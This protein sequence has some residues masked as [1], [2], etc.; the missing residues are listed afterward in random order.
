MDRNQSVIVGLAK[1]EVKAPFKYGNHK[2]LLSS[3]A[4]GPLSEVN[5]Q[6]N[7]SSLVAQSAV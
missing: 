5:P 7:K 1:V 3:D 2:A 4:K 6:L